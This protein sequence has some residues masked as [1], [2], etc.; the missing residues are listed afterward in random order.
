MARKSPR[1]GPAGSCTPWPVATVRVNHQTP[2][3]AA[4][5]PSQNPFPIG[6]A[7]IWLTIPAKSGEVATSR[8]ER[9]TVMCCS[10]AN[11]ATKCTESSTPASASRRRTAA[12]RA[13]PPAFPPIRR[14][15]TTSP[16]ARLSRHAVRP[17][18]DMP[19][20]RPYRARMAALPTAACAPSRAAYALAGGRAASL[21]RPLGPWGGRCVWFVSL[22]EGIG[23][24]CA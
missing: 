22:A 16:A 14:T 21:M 4:S 18:A 9:A 12:D 1:Q 5:R 3:P 15:A 6:R 11:Q 7:S 23:A 19:A 10:E 8:V 20:S 2:P 13:S 17:G 24:R